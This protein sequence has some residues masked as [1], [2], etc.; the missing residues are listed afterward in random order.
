MNSLVLD[1]DQGLALVLFG[2]CP[3][4]PIVEFDHLLHEVVGDL[5][6]D[7]VSAVLEEHVEDKDYSLDCHLPHDR[8]RAEL[9]LMQ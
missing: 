6:D 3:L 7:I 4:G 5:Q 9:S 8:G 1:L 2:I